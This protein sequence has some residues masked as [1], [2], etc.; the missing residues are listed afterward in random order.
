MR[1]DQTHRP[2]F[3]AS[4]TI[5]AIAAAVFMTARPTRKWMIEVARRQQKWRPIA[6]FMSIMGTPEAD[7]ADVRRVAVGA[8]WSALAIAAVLALLLKLEDRR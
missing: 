2:W 5:L 1:I 7:I 6:K 3:F 4:L 8:T